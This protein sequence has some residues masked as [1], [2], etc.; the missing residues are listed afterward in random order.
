M[1][2]NVNIKE[3]ILTEILAKLYLEGEFLL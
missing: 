1:N 3:G 2:V